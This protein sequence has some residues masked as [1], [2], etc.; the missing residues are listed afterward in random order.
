MHHVFNESKCCSS[1]S[2]PTKPCGFQLCFQELGRVK[3]QTVH[4]KENMWIHTCMQ[5]LN[6]HNGRGQMSNGAQGTNV[7]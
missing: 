4:R 2:S 7:P 3:A 6:S 1:I 5:V